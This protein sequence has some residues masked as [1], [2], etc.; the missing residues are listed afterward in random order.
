MRSMYE[1]GLHWSVWATS[2]A[3][4]RGQ[5]AKHLIAAGVLMRDTHSRVWPRPTVSARAQDIMA[6]TDVSNRSWVRVC[7]PSPCISALCPAARAIAGL[8]PQS[9][10]YFVVNRGRGLLCCLD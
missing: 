9:C 10:P 3:T 7:S 8:L 1:Q 5:S 6:N 4:L 2:S